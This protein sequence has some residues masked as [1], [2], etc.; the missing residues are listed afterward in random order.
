MSLEAQFIQAN[1]FGAE[2][3][4]RA[5][6]SG[7]LARGSTVGSVVGGLAHT[8]DLAIIA[9]TGMQVKVEP[10]ECFVPGTVSASQGAYYT[11]LT[12]QMALSIP[13]AEASLP[14]VERIVVWIEDAAYAGSGNAPLLSVV[15]GTAESGAT[16][17][18]KKGASAAPAS[19]LTI[20]YV[21]VPA[22]AT[23]I[24]AADIETTARVASPG[25]QTFEEGTAAER[26]VAAVKGRIYYATD[27]KVLSFDNGTTWMEAA[28]AGGLAWGYI[29][30]SGNIIASTG[31]F[32]VA[33]TATGKYEVKWATAK[34][35]AYYAITYGA[36]GLSVTRQSTTNVEADAFTL[37][38][39]EWNATSKAWGAANMPF[40]FSCNA[41]GL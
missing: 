18:N 12:S 33:K 16:L 22:K 2:V 41:T 1:T 29:G 9:G 31:G 32:T 7:L 34:P 27:T 10:G 5:I 6:Y 14:R 30:E 21:L 36:V 8:G 15:K 37:I 26:P 38:A 39:E 17:A 13:A 24:E 19:S 25:L 20:G 3:T 23:S 4:R 35:A 11:R 28:T 40:F